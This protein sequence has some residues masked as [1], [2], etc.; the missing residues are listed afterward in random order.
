MV[1]MHN[2]DQSRPLYIALS[3]GVSKF[4]SMAFFFVSF[5]SSPLVCLRLAQDSTMLLSPIKTI[6]I[7]CQGKQK[8]KVFSVDPWD[9][10]LDW[11]AVMFGF[12]LSLLFWPLRAKRHM[13]TRTHTHGYHSRN[14]PW[15]FQ[16]N[17]QH[18]SLF[19]ALIHFLL[20]F[21]NNYTVY[22][23]KWSMPGTLIVLC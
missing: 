1:I 23:P 3:W 10:A 20:S 9:K 7:I 6:G 22:A 13:H 11:R 8:G 14:Y 21:C 12:C 4:T 5:P 2:W 16:H 19:L 18:F 17:G 15:A